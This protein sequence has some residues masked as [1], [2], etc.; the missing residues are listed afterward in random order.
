MRK[1]IVLDS[2]DSYELFVFW[3]IQTTHKIET[4]QGLEIE[5]ISLGVPA[6][7]DP[8]LGI[9]EL[10]VCPPGENSK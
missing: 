9:T 6:D 1:T 7:I 4:I 2:E 8:A 5:H 3:L 10:I